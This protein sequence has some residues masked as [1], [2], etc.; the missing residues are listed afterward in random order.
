MPND[1]STTTIDDSN[2]D[3][4]SKEFFGNAEP[5]EPA[6]EEK[7]DDKVEDAEDT[8]SEEDTL[9]TK[10]QEDD[11]ADSDDNEEDEEEETPPEK[12]KKKTVQERINDITRDKHEALRRAEAAEK[13][14]EDLRAT[15]IEKKDTVVAVATDGP[16]PEDTNEDGT[17]KY[18]LGEYDPKY[19]RDLTKH[20]IS[21]E[22][23]VQKEQDQLERAAR[24]KQA[25]AEAL[26]QTW[27]DKADKSELNIEEAGKNLA[28]IF[29]AVNGDY[30]EYLAATIMD[31]EKGPEVFHY[32]SN[33][34][35]E[36]ER[37]VASGPRAA[38]IALGRLE[39][40]FLEPATKKP[41]VSQAPEPPKNLNRGS[42]GRFDVPDDTDDLDAF[43][44]KMYGKK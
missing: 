32:L 15:R 39:A 26:S 11:E 35:D 2:L 33:H 5:K 20:T 37:I 21:Q 6:T 1:D 12:P 41:K 3:D 38:T 31:M 4:F 19:I 10:E 42:N 9:A 27:K 7:E 43:A 28:P 30:G 14:L 25:E 36:A 22:T 34:L 40:K 24:H 44:E 13:A 23:A 18:P 17:D 8:S 16:T 29:T